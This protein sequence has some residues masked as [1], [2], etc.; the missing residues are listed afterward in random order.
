MWMFPKGSSI[1]F[2]LLRTLHHSSF[3]SSSHKPL[4]QSSHTAYVQYAQQSDIYKHQLWNIYHYVQHPHHLEL[5]TWLA[6]LLFRSK[7][8]SVFFYRIGITVFKNIYII[9][10]I[11]VVQLRSEWNNKILQLFLKNDFIILD[12]SYIG[13]GRL[14]ELDIFCLFSSS[15]K[16]LVEEII[17]TLTVEKF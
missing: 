6:L 5:H 3:G 9:L 17:N 13:R 12:H 2:D 16:C 4:V 8:I 7:L 14:M 15:P 1:H 10:T 11:Y